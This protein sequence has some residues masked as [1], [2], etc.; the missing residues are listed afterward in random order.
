MHIYL[1]GGRSANLKPLLQRIYDRGGGDMIIALAGYFSRPWGIEQWYE[2]A[3]L[4]PNNTK[5]QGLR[6][7]G[8][9]ESILGRG[10]AVEGRRNL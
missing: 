2:A 8:K 6:R 7:G 3:G 4:L 5:A 1:A 9:N 10:C